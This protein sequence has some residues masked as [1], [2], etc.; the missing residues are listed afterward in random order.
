MDADG[1]TVPPT[2]A[3]PVQDRTIL[4]PGCG[5]DLR[6][7]TE[8]RCSECG[9]TIDR[10]ALDRSGFPW[11][12]RQRLGRSRAF[13]KTVLLVTLDHRSLRH[14]TARPQSP[15]DAAAF[16]RCVA[17]VLAACFVVL[18][19]PFLL[20]NEL[21]SELAHAVPFSVEAMQS[22]GWLQDLVVP[23]FAGVLL[24]PS[25]FGCVVGLAWYVAG[26]GRA[27]FRSA[28]SAGTY[29]DTVEAI[30]DYVAAPLV[31]LVPATVSFASLYVREVYGPFGRGGQLT[32]IL[33]IVTWLLVLAAFGGTL[34]RVGQWRARTTHRG[35]ATAL[36]SIVELLFRWTL[37]VIALLGV[38]PWCVG[39]AWIAANSLR[40]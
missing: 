3:A 37:G 14:E 30:G 23:W 10:A 17:A 6:A 29:A 40:R 9:L 2:D 26:A 8:G 15:R 20:D 18:I 39:V 13:W 22:P 32:V 7:A 31:L 25:L 19:S 16:R 28:R 35:F 11:A 33:I 12:H 5:Y 36:L 38:V 34:I 4:C 1:S 21:S 27:V 24:R